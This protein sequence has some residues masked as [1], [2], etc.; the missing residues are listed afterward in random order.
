MDMHFSAAD[1]AFRDEVRAFLDARLAPDLREAMRNT[2][3]VFT[4]PDVSLRWQRILHAQGWL[5]WHWPKE[6]G[7][8][9]WTATQR[10]LFEKECALA[11]APSLSPM[12]LR[13]VAP[14]VMT[15]GTPAQREFFLPKILSSEHYWCQGYSEPGSGSDLASLST[16]AE[17]RG[18]HYVINGSKIWTTHAHHANWMFCLVRTDASAKPQ[19]GITFLLIDMKQPGLQVRPIITMAGDH[20]VNQVFFDDVKVPV[21]QRVGEE[22]QGWEIAKFLLEY[23]RGGGAHAP[24]LL[25]DIAVLRRAAA[26]LPGDDGGTLDADPSFMADLAKLEIAAQALEIGELRLLAEL[27]QGRRPGPQSSMQKLVG[28]NLRQALD[29]LCVRAYGYDGLQLEPARPLYG[30]DRPEPVGPGAAQIAMPRWL[31]SRAWTIFGGS[32]EVQKNILAKAFLGL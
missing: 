21:S 19:R 22:G 3:S 4:E 26:A 17:L 31:N 18:D 7:G 24:K 15:Y 27:A 5:A 11:N 9:G 1:L 23:E 6:H 16:R 2:P 20:E 25:A 13:F 32:S 14:V 29:T 12:G 8:T 30:A 10:Y 28:S